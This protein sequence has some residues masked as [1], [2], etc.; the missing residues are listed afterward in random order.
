MVAIQGWVAVGADAINVF[1]QTSPPKEPMFVH[2]DDHMVEWME[3]TMGKRPDRTLVLPILC[4]LQGHHD[5]VSLWADKVEQLV[6]TDLNIVCATHET[7]LYVGQYSGQEV[8][9]GRQVDGFMALVLQESRLQ[10]L[11]GYLA[12]KIKIEA[13]AGLM[14]HCN[15]IEIIQDHDYVKIHVGKYKIL[16][17]HGWEQATKA[18]ARL[19]EPLHPSTFRELE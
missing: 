10:D 8:L 13:E 9:I 1:A 3:E 6:V 2:I 7:C 16:T 4:A 19:I 18:E 17:N 14:S 5:A 11:F 12:T 15:S